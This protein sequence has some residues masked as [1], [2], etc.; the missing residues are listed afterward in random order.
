MAIGQV[1][2]YCAMC[3][4]H[5]GVVATVSEG[6][7]TK[8]TPDP[9]HPNGGICVKGTAAPE[10]VYA[11]DRLRHPM[12]RTHPKDD[13]DPGW[14]RISWDE[15]LALTAWR[16]LEI[17]ARHGPE[18]VAF[19]IATP[20]GSAAVDFM[21][22]AW[23]L[24]NAFGSPNVV[25]N[26]HICQ[27]HRD[28][29]AAYTYGVGTP[30]PD[31]E[32]ARCILLWGFNPRATWPGMSMRI[33]QATAD[34]ARLIVIDPRR[35][36]LAGKAD[37]WLRV[38]P[39]ADG[40]LA[41]GM[42]HVLLEEGLADEDFVRDW[43]NAPFLVRADT[44]QLLA[45]PDLSAAADPDSFVVWDRHGGGPAAY[46]PGGGYD[47]P[48]VQPALSGTYRV[49]GAGGE[50]LS[51]R[52]AL[53]LLGE[54]AARYAP[55]RSEALTGVPAALVRR[56]VR[57]FSNE[58]PSCY[59]TWAGLEQRRDAAQT[60]RAIGLFY[61]LTGQFDQRGS[62]VLFASTPH[63]SRDGPSAAPGRAGGA[64]PRLRRTPAGPG[65]GTRNGADGRRLPGHPHRT[66]LSGAG[67]GR[68]RVRPPARARQ[69]AARQTGPAGTRLLRARR[70]VRQPQRFPGRPAPARG[71]LLGDRGRPAVPAAVRSDG[72]HQHL[73]AVPAG[74][75]AA[76]ARGAARPGDHLRPG[77]ATGPGR[78]FFRRGHRVGLRLSAGAFGAERPAASRA[79]RG[80][81][82]PRP[83]PI[84]EIRR[85]RR[86]YRAAPRLCDPHA[87]AGDL[88][89]QLRQGGPRAAGG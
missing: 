47:R 56:A 82:G 48:A 40:A 12:V 26:T 72:A 77:S 60:N 64:S 63:E 81:A 10:L 31:Y 6:V 37:L 20:A 84:P 71:Q 88:F 74:R 69:S 3:V 27:W 22:W 65:R 41:L 29:G 51:C 16:L 19:P 76:R 5:C 54:L 49:T 17:K 25:T 24:A 78:P 83:D 32:H 23:R 28:W 33:G 73:G 1:H 66:T 61:A 9:A 46:R 42:I 43:T 80:R 75:R 4:S 39:G 18:A 85:D 14:A 87:Q 89:D 11:P 15:A 57:L 70:P 59:Y 79:S 2:T 38:R 62:N 86:A 44:G 58:R 36:A 8:V 7:L 35:T 68:V 21:P 55:G 67:P 52:P 50:T 30:P 53:E 34:G 45:G 13:P